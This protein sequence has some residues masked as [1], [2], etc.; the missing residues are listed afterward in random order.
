MVD[1]QAAMDAASHFQAPLCHR[2]AE[3]TSFEQPSAGA[4]RSFPSR[5]DRESMRLAS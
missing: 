5:D 1:G 4:K 3:A 2:G